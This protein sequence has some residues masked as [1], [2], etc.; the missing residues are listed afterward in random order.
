MKQ[1]P[2]SDQWDAVMKQRDGWMR[3]LEKFRQANDLDNPLDLGL[4]LP[5]RTEGA[6]LSAFDPT[7]LADMCGISKV[8]VEG[9]TLQVIDL[10]DQPRCDRSWKRDGTV[11]AYTWEDNDVMLSTRDAAAVGVA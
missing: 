6:D 11:K 2:V 1:I 10:R 8:T 5:A 7:D 4:V 9:D 3:E